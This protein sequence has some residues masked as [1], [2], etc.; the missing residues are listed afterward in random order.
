MVRAAVAFTAAVALLVLLGWALDIRVLKSVLPHLTT[1]KAN[2]AACLG[3]TA[4]ALWLSRTAES[5]LRH[6]VAVWAIAAV[7]MATAAIT[8]G[9]YAFGWNAGIDELLF[10]D[11]LHAG[12]QYPPGRFAPG[13]GICCLLFSG[14]LLAIDVRPRV[15]EGFTLAGLLV[16][17]IGLIGYLYSLPTLYGAGLYTSLALHTV[18]GF[19]AIGTGIAAARPRRGIALLFGDPEIRPLMTGAVL[20]PMVLGSF[21][22]VGQRLGW[23]GGEFTLALFSMLLMLFTAALVWKTGRERQRVD[24]QRRQ[25]EEELRR[26]NLELESRVRDRTQDLV[27]ANKEMEAFSYSVSH[28][29][30]APLRSIDGFSEILLEDHAAQLDEEGRRYLERIRANAKG[31]SGLISDMLTLAKISRAEL[32]REEIDL[33]ELALKVLAALRAQ[34]PG[35]MMEVEIEPWL[36]A[37]ADP[38]LVRV[39]LENLLGNAW[40]FTAKTAL[41]R[42]RFGQAAGREPVFYVEDNGAGFDMALA[43]RIFEPFQRL[44]S[45]GDFEGS[46]IGLATVQRIVHRHGGSI[47]AEGRVGGGARFFFSLEAVSAAEFAKAAPVLKKTAYE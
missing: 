18:A 44:H 11:P 2:T 46:G 30:R 20:F 29:L 27:A 15:S 43:E 31:M 8:L 24:A 37:R 22:L 14:A 1:M 13:T 17:V 9:E 47:R 26:L 21:S 42:I 38:R 4:A 45:A 25:A 19:L 16:A 28:D 12:T 7:V 39:A 40:K 34:E 36:T 10:R 23:Y 32:K 35:R 6:R 5:R 3:L 33:S 41:G